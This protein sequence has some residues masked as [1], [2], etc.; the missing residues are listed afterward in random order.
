[1]TEKNLSKSFDELIK[2]STKPVLTDF[3][4]DWRGPCKMV[5]PYNKKNCKRLKIH[6]LSRWI[7]LAM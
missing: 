3:Y 6:L 5:S 7:F 2:T 4:A 1:M